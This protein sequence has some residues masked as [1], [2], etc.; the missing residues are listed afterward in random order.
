MFIATANSLSEIPE[1]LRD[2]FKIIQVSGY[3]MEEKVEI[4][5]RHLW[6][7]ALRDNRFAPGEVKIA[8]SALEEIATHYT[9]EAGVRRMEG[10]LTDILGGV[11]QEDREG[12]VRTGPILP[13]ELERYLGPMAYPPQDIDLQDAVGTVN[14][15]YAGGGS[16]GGVMKIDAVHDKEGALRRAFNIE[17]SGNLGKVMRE[18]TELISRMFRLRAR[19]LQIDPKNLKRA[20]YI[21]AREGGMPKEGPSAGAAMFL[22]AYSALKGEPIKGD[23]ALTGEVTLHG[24]VTKIGGVSEKLT[25]A[26]LA[27]IRTVLLPRANLRD[28]PKKFFDLL[29]IRPVDTV[30]DVLRHGLVNGAVLFPRADNQNVEQRGAPQ[31]LRAVLTPKGR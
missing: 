18:S 22:L 15:L 28:V 1:P 7:R 21:H 29:D 13:A 16:G 23:L 27:G 10:L 5:D 20:L 25:G 30:E 14:A 19:P 11:A 26:Q 6:G 9:R 2:R 4:A 24:Q 17:A 8:R 3:T 12:K 31:P